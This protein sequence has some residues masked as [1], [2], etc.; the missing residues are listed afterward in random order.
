MIPD[1]VP[2]SILWY[3]ITVDGPLEFMIVGSFEF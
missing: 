1:T 2:D 3:V